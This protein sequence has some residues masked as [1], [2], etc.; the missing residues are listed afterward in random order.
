VEQQIVSVK[1]AGSLL[2]TIKNL[3]RAFL[4]TLQRRI[5]KNGM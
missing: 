2:Q 5:E 4:R 3:K 1:R